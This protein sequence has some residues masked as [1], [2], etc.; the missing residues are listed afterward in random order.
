MKHVRLSPAQL[1]DIRLLYPQIYA[2]KCQCLLAPLLGAVWAELL[3][4]DF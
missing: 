3:T 1:S 4:C 2:P